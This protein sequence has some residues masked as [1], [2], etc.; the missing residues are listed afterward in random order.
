VPSVSD[1]RATRRYGPTDRALSTPPPLEVD[2]RQRGM[3]RSSDSSLEAQSFERLRARLTAIAAPAPPPIDPRSV[4]LRALVI[5]DSFDQPEAVNRLAAAKAA[6]AALTCVPDLR[7]A[8]R[9][10]LFVA[11]KLEEPEQKD[12]WGAWAARTWTLLA[13]LFGEVSGIARSVLH[14]V[15][16]MTFPSIPSLVLS[17]QEAQSPSAREA[18][19][20]PIPRLAPLAL[21][22]LGLA[23]GELGL[24]SSPSELRVASAGDLASLEPVRAAPRFNIELQVSVFSESNLYAGFTENLSASGI[25]VATHVLRPIGSSIEVSVLFPGRSEPVRLRGE[26][27]WRREISEGSDGWPGMGIRFESLTPEQNALMAEFLRTREPI[28]FDE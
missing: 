19:A 4:A 8:A 25:F 17:Q 15:P 14:D 18:H 16:G 23:R 21:E 5:V 24:G 20:A 22:G 11:S 3:A 2:S 27:R 12:Q 28:F 10:A 6:G 9:A 13:E 7:E 1:E 26:V